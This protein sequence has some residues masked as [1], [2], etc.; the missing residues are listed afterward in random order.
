M[1]GHNVSVCLLNPPEVIRGVLRKQDE[2]GVWVYYGF[3]GQ[4][5]L[6][7]FPM[8]RIERIEDNGDVYR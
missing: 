7:F 1:L 4:A 5:K 8:H 3:Q 2:T 6:H